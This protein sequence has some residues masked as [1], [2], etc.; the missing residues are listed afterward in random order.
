MENEKE[1]LENLDAEK[2]YFIL[3]NGTLMPNNRKFNKLTVF[4]DTFIEET[5]DS[6][7]E[8]LHDYYFIQLTIN[9]IIKHL[10]N[11]EKLENLKGDAV[12]SSHTNEFKLKINE[13]TF[14]VNRNVLNEE[15]RQL[16]DE[17]I[18]DLYKALNI[19]K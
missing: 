19:K 5:E 15:G 3:F 14:R 13:K 1:R 16:Y 11:I 4:E 10:T 12:K 7:R 18:N 2:F 6:R 8:N 9:T 17:F